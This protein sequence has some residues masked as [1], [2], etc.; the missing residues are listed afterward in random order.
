MILT[1]NLSISLVNGLQGKNFDVPKKDSQPI[2]VNF[3]GKCHNIIKKQFDVYD[4]ISKSNIASRLQYS[5]Q[6]SYALTIHRVQGQ[7]IQ[8]VII[9]CN[10]I[11]KAGQLGVAVGR[12]TNV[13]RIQILNINS[14]CVLKHPRM[15]Y[16]FDTVVSTGLLML[17]L[18]SPC[19]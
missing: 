9:D 15:V 5:L 4:P 13:D 2:V 8:H 11:F 6:L 19:V 16:D 1:A 17:Y 12:A 7:T 18:Y 10:G 14:G 3:N